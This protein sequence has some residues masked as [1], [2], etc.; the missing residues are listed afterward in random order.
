MPSTRS[1]RKGSMQYWPRKRA[2]RQ[3]ARVRSW[4]GSGK[5]GPVGFAGYK[6]GMTTMI[7]S[8]KNHLSKKGEM[9]DVA[10]PITVIECPPIKVASVRFYKKDAY[11]LKVAFEVFGKVDKELG[12]KIK[13]PKKTDEAKLDAVNLAECDD[14][15]LNV[16]TMPSRTGIGK[17]KPEIFELGLEGSIEEKF[18]YA[19][20]RLGKEIRVDEVFSEGAQLDIHSVTGGKGFQGPV[21]RFGVGLRSHKS[22][23]VKRGPGSLGGWKAQGHFMY[24][25]AHAGKMGYHARN[26]WNK[27][28]LKISDKPEEINPKGGFVRY[29]VVKNPYI[30]VK[31]SVGG[32][33]KRMI[34]ITNA[35]RPNPKLPKERPQIKYISLE[36]KQRK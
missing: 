17:K 24:R 15:R 21:K 29:G 6:A 7:I 8:A 2:K 30:L 26:E 36:S 5:P 18:N 16:Y 25:V 19:K 11:G 20:E 4:A 31:G 10:I 22:E 33:A 23:K 12:R 3:Y 28:L 13:V 32:P 14:I 35:R 34:K 1:P 9:L 27:W